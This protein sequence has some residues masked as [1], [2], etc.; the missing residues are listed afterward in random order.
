LEYLGVPD[1][2]VVVAGIT[3]TNS[4][5]VTFFIPVGFEKVLLSL[6]PTEQKSFLSIGVDFIIDINS[7]VI[8]S[9]SARMPTEI[10][11]YTRRCGKYTPN[12]LES[13]LSIY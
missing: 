10:N 2:S 12:P 9:Q 5:M 7:C 8:D 11:Y 6:D 4:Y 1:H 13:L 3:L